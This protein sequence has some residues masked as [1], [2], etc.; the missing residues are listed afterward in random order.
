MREIVL[1]MLEKEK[2]P[3][4]TNTLHQGVLKIPEHIN[5][6]KFQYPFNCSKDQAKE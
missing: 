4:E 5:K 6:T 1:Q 3:N 2:G